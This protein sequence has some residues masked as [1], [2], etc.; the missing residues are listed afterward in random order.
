MGT[1]DGAWMV[2][3]IH[4]SHLSR[5]GAAIQPAL[6]QDNRVFDPCR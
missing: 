3:R 2:V 1:H 6:T 5:A 4:Y